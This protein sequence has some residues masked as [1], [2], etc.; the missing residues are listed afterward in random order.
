MTYQSE[1]PVEIVPETQIYYAPNPDYDLYRYDGYWYVNR[2]G[3]WYRARSYRGPFGPIVYDRV[4]HAIIAI[5]GSYHHHP[6]HPASWHRG[7]EPHRGGRH[8]HDH[9][10][11]HDHDH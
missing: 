2:N 5:P 4:P 9:H 8:D 10:R 1:P 3:Y 6:M 7:P 11:G